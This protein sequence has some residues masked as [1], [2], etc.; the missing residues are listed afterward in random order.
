MSM[1]IHH[2]SRKVVMGVLALALPLS[3]VAILG[4]PAVA[5]K[6]PPNPILCQNLGGTVTFQAPGLSKNGVSG[7]LSKTATTTITGITLTCPNVNAS[8][9]AAASVTTKNSKDPKVKHQPRTYTYGTF[10]QFFASS[11]AVKKSIKTLAFRINGQ[12]ATFKNKLVTVDPGIQC[13]GEVGFVLS[14][15]V[16]DPAYNT[17][18]A[19]VIVC[20]GDDTGT[21][22]THSFAHDLGSPSSVI[23]SAVIDP[24]ESEATL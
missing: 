9:P 6:P 18:E 13:N 16:K 14:G 12:P 7:S 5:K 20:L 10:V 4:S 17:K 1:T 22:I 24:E 8:G 2:R 3:G 21:G 23:T 15:Q 19:E 11:T